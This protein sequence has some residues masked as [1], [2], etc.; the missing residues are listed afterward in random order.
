MVN[1]GPVALGQSERE[2]LNIML[3]LDK[4][5][6]ILAGVEAVGGPNFLDEGLSDR[7]EHRPD[8]HYR[9]RQLGQTTP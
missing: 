9:R 3:M 5:A 8:E 6:S 4:W 1:H 2:V 7:I